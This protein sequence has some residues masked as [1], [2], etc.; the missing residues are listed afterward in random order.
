[1][2]YEHLTKE[3]LDFVLARTSPHSFKHNIERMNA[4]FRLPINTEPTLFGLHKPNGDPELPSNRL[5]GFL[6]TIRDEADEGDTDKGG[7]VGQGGI[8]AKLLALEAESDNGQASADTEAVKDVLVDLADWLGDMMVYIRSEAMK[9]GLPIEECLEAINGSNF[10]KLPA[11]G[12]PIHDANGK[13]L[14][15]M[16]RFIPPEPA[17]KTIMWGLGD[18]NG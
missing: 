6:K 7:V 18:S 3:Q 16:S 9:Y 8:L 17:L 5:K 15:D 2:S 14:K 12:I 11:D 1:M 10:T 13:F 4:M